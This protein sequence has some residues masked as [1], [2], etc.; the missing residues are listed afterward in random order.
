MCLFVSV[1]LGADDRAKSVIRTRT[2]PGDVFRPP[3]VD[4]GLYLIRIGLGDIAALTAFSI[5]EG[6]VAEL[7]KFLRV[8]VDNGGTPDMRAAADTA[9]YSHKSKY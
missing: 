1:E 7:D 4:I 5:E 6:F 3:F 2:V 9:L 8:G